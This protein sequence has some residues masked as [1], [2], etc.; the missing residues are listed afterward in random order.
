MHQSIPLNKQNTSQA[1]FFGTHT[2][3]T[4]VIN[5]TI[6]FVAI[7]V[8]EA[9]DITNT[10]NATSRLDDDEKDVHN[11]D[12]LGGQQGMTII[13]ESG[14]YNLVLSSRKPEA[15]KFKKWVT[16]EVLP[17]IRKKGVYIQDPE[18]LELAIAAASEVADQVTR[19][20]FEA[21]LLSK[22]F[23]ILVLTF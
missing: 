13:N 20:V 14:L 22:D 2:V 9:L 1:F 3:R 21:V 5:E 12:T 10:R 17:T 7:D 18:R 11:M 23:D 4:V 19:S 15:K 8:C 16:S 6:W